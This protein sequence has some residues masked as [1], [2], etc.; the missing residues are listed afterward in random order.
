MF[1]TGIILIVL[2][3]LLSIPILYSIGVVLAIIG[4]IL[5]VLGSIGRTVGNRKH[6]W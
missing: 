1:L 6:Y 3:V 4:I 5:W 2:G